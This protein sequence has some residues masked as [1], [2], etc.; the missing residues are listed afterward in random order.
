MFVLLLMLH[1]YFIKQPKTHKN[2]FSTWPNYKNH[3]T[4]KCL[5]AVAPNYSTIFVSKAR[6]GSLFDKKLSSK[7]K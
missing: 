7:C 2:Q 3:D 4:I 6:C 5:A 1:N